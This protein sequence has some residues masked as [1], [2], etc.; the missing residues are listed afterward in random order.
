[1]RLLFKFFGKF[2]GLTKISGKF[3]KIKNN[4]FGRLLLAELIMF[5]QFGKDK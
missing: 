5:D 3:N 4:D 2:G 1:M